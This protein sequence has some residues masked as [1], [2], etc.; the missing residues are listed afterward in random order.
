MPGGGIHKRAVAHGADCQQRL[1][2]TF[3]HHLKARQDRMSPGSL[4]LNLLPRAT[5]HK[6]AFGTNDDEF[7]LLTDILSTYWDPAARSRESGWSIAER[8]ADEFI[9]SSQCEH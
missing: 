2:K 5:A 8:R 6:L 4:A 1:A 9:S 7:P 3:Q